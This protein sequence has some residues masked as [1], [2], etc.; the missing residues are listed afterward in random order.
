MA[1]AHQP[2]EGS[3]LALIMPGG[4]RHPWPDLLPDEH[5]ETSELLQSLLPPSVQLK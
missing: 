5:M 2:T 4:G 1:T 3:A